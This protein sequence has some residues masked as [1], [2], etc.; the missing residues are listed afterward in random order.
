MIALEVGKSL[1]FLLSPF[2]SLHSYT[3]LQASNPIRIRISVSPP[4]H[5]CSTHYRRDRTSR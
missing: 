2:D 3:P 4:P 5:S 1:F